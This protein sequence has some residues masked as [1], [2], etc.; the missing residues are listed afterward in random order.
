MQRRSDPGLIEDRA[1]GLL[2]FFKG[3]VDSRNFDLSALLRKKV[4]SS[5]WKR[6]VTSCGNL[7]RNA[8]VDRAKQD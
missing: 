4:L 2:L 5:L 8:K 3:S 7:S 1:L 6:Q